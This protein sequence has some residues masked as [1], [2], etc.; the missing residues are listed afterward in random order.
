MAASA[1][2]PWLYARAFIVLVGVSLAVR[3]LPFRVVAGWSIRPGW[4]RRTTLCSAEVRRAIEAWSRRLP[5]RALCLEQGLATAR[6]LA[7]NGTPLALFYGAAMIDGEVKAHVW[8]RSGDQDVVG[9]ESADQFAI[10]ARFSNSSSSSGVQPVLYKK[11]GKEKCD[12][13]ADAG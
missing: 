1:P 11:A 13:E 2:S 10:L 6:L 12:D 5:W 8:V 7:G 4:A 9:C 3:V